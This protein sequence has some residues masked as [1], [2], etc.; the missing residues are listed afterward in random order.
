M[1]FDVK[2]TLDG[3][4][5]EHTDIV[6]KCVQDGERWVDETRSRMESWNDEWPDQSE[7]ADK[8]EL[9]RGKIQLAVSLLNTIRS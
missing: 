5:S 3:T 2:Q 4:K 9:W 1:A 7:K 6:D 8:W